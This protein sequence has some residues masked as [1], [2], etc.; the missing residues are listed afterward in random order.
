MTTT[1]VVLT[2][3]DARA[4]ATPPKAPRKRKGK[5]VLPPA[6]EVSSTG[7]PTVPTVPTA[8]T[9]PTAPTTPTPPPGRF[10]P[11]HCVDPE[12]LDAAY[13]MLPATDIMQLYILTDVGGRARAKVERGVNDPLI[14]QTGMLEGLTAR[15]AWLR[16]Y[17]RR[18]P[19]RPYRMCQAS[20]MLEVQ[21]GWMR[22]V[23]EPRQGLVMDEHLPLLSSLYV[24]FAEDKFPGSTLDVIFDPDD[25]STLVRSYTQIRQLLRGALSLF[26]AAI[27]KVDD[28]E[29][30][31]TAQ[32]ALKLLRELPPLDKYGDATA[33]ERRKRRFDMHA[34]ELELEDEDGFL[35]TRKAPPGT[36]GMY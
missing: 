34:M 7:A 17:A 2:M 22:G 5:E 4:P 31:E 3:A 25:T 26:A 16:H 10:S 23:P 8:P 18:P 33:Y 36:G 21:E 6:P 32:L 19:C 12:A 28:G 15:Y 29:A 24:A 30:K 20:T 13:E 35:P 14:G 9:A 1:T 11:L 27:D